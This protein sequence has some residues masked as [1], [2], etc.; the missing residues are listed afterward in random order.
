MM[1]NFRRL[2]TLQTAFDT[3]FALVWYHTDTKRGRFYYH[4]LFSKKRDTKRMNI[5]YPGDTNQS[6]FYYHRRNNV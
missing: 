4:A 2:W 1:K 6:I 5:Y 3:A